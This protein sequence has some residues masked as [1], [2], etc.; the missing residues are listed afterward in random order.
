MKDHN[1][2]GGDI[3]LGDCELNLRDILHPVDGQASTVEQWLPLSNG[4][5]EL[6]VKLEFSPGEEVDENGGKHKLSR[7][8]TALI[9]K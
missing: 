1:T 3:D 5:G 2:F 6:H 8:L 4:G 7:G 9:K